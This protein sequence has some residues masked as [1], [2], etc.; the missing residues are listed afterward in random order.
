VVRAA[1]PPL[2]GA[3]LLALDAIGAPPAAHDRLRA[4]FTADQP[5]AAP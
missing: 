1:Y 4:E 5:S 3:A 2:V